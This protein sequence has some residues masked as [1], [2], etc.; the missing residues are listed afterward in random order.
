MSIHHNLK[1]IKLVA[2]YYAQHHKCNYNVIILNPDS[3]GKY[4]REAGSTY[5]FVRDSYFEK[6]RPNAILIYKTDSQ[7]EKD[8]CTLTDQ[9]LVAKVKNWNSLL[10]KTGGKAWVLRIPAD[11][12]QDPDLLIAELCNRFELKQKNH[13]Q[14]NT[15]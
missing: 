13:D 7:K 9:E 5:E 12:N 4:N 3:D 1:Q 8:I 2:D 6:D 10:C 11:R 14:E 15:N